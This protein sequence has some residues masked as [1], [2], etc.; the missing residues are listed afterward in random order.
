MKHRMIRHKTACSFLILFFLL[1]SRAKSLLA[2]VCAFVLFIVLNKTMGL[3]VT[4]EEEIEGLDMH[5][6]GMSAYANFRLHDDR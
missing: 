5:E 3:R 4:A 2:W 6:H 1:L